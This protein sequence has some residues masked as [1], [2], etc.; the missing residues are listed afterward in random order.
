MEQSKTQTRSWRFLYQTGLKRNYGFASTGWER[1]FLNSLKTPLERADTL[2]KANRFTEPECSR[3]PLNDDSPHWTAILFTDVE[4]SKG[5][6]VRKRTL[7]RNVLKCLFIDRIFCSMSTPKS[8]LTTVNNKS[9]FTIR[10]NNW[11]IKKNHRAW[12]LSKAFLGN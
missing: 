8:S 7:K 6:G 1:A 12:W 2:K 3:M 10:Q 11:F 9:H 4:S 5:V